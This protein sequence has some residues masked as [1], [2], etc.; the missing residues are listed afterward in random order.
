[1]RTFHIK[2]LIPKS[3]VSLKFS[4]VLLKKIIK[5]K[6]KKEKKKKRRP[7]DLRLQRKQLLCYCNC[8]I[9]QF[10]PKSH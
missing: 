5:K 10:I 1:M 3:N 6:K 8:R 7:E 4:A 9:G 2:S